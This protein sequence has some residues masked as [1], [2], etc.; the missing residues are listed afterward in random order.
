M[1]TINTIEFI[2][3]IEKN[4]CGYACLT[5]LFNYFNYDITLSQ[6]RKE[7]G[8]VKGGISFQDMKTI[9]TNYGINSNAY[10]INPNDINELNN[11]GIIQWNNNTHFVILHKI[12]KNQVSVIDP[13][14]GEL[15]LSIKDF[16]Q[17]FN[18]KIFIIESENKIHKK[19]IILTCWMP[20]L[21]L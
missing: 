17:T 4:E 3:Q 15:K 14:Y 20:F 6:L 18:G 2:E 19:S 21:I 9:C 1:R 13:A 10:K 16:Y 12:S 8:T 5:M 7:Y 11:P